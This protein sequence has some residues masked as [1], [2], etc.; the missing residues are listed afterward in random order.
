MINAEWERITGKKVGKST[1][2]VRYPRI[3]ASLACVASEDVEQMLASKTKIEE[4]IQ[5]EIKELHNKMWSRVAKDMEEAGKQNYPVSYHCPSVV[6]HSS[7]L[8]SLLIHRLLRWRSTS[9]R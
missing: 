2:S 7:V 3:K 4:T 8:I 9:R 6:H 1:L 5:A